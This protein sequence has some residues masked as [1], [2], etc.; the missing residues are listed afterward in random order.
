MKFLREF[1]FLIVF[2]G[3]VAG[4]GSGQIVGG[5]IT[6]TVNDP[7]GA[8]VA[9]AAVLVRQAETGAT[10]TLTTTADGRFFAP[11]VPVGHYS[12]TVSLDGF[13]SQHQSGID[14]TVGQSLQLHFVLG[15][16]KVQQEV[17]VDATG[18]SVNVTTQSTV[19]PD[20]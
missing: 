9:G 16:A 20:R 2:L 14:L 4:A 11:S 17:E 5:S 7:N 13:D 12:V 15:L 3:F 19:G 18:D 6:G 10:R 1:S 8:T